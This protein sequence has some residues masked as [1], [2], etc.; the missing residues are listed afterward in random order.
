[1]A[2]HPRMR[3]CTSQNLSERW[4]ACLQSVEVNESTVVPLNILVSDGAFVAVVTLNNCL[5]SCQPNADKQ[6]GQGRSSQVSTLPR[7]FTHV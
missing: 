6:A 1:M 7:R 2:L 4:R 5:H 3:S